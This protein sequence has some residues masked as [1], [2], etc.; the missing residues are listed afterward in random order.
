MGAG[1][2]FVH[3]GAFSRKGNKQGQS[4]DFIFG[5]AERRPDASLHVANPSPPEVVYGLTLPEVR[6]LHDERTSDARDVMK[7]G[8]TRAI[9]STQQTLATVIASHPYSVAE[10]RTDPAKAGEVA[11]WE[12][13][14]VKWLKDQFG[15]QLVSVIRHNDERHCH[16]HCYILP[17]NSMMKAAAIHPGHIAKASV[18]ADGPRPGENERTLNKR[19]DKAYR[20]AMRVWQDNY[21]QHVG[22]PCGLTRIG[23]QVRRLK[24]AEWQAEMQA[25]Q[26]LKNS[27]VRAEAL[28]AKRDGFVRETKQEAGKFIERTRKQASETIENAKREAVAIGLEAAAIRSAAERQLQ[29][30]KDANAAALAA[31]GHALKAQE[32]AQEMMSDARRY[33]GW[34]G[35]L[36]AI[37]DGL[38]R[39]KIV[40]KIRQELAPEIERANAFAKSVQHKLKDEEEKRRSAEREA[41]DA[42]REVR[43]AKDAALRAGIER[44]RA[45]A[46]LPL[47][48]QQHVAVVG[49]MSMVLKPKQKRE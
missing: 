3:L 16:L 4:T 35:R 32:Q 30:A 25:A 13:R 45:W 34:G 12:R 44:D 40:E 46:M 43:V 39:S 37:W 11:D 1:Y 27:L 7:N 47:E 24:R 23:P 8:R 28:N 31:Q 33:S 9:R 48:R 38:R 10:V 18:L 22:A 42:A 41:L 2:Q 36:R 49:S 21:F 14:T 19:G 15:S 26:A 29:S 5:E 6:T 17:G 20:A